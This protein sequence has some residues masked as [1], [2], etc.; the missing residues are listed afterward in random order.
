MLWSYDL[1][2]LLVEK[3]PGM[4]KAPCVATQQKKV[5]GLLQGSKSPTRSCNSR[6]RGG[7]VHLYAKYKKSI[8]IG[9]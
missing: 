5:N 8:Y 9:C 6:I 3:S 1:F 2:Y 7:Q 4:F